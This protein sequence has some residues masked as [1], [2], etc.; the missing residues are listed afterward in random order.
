MSP[1]CSSTT[2]LQLK[3]VIQTEMGQ[4]Q[5]EKLSVIVFANKYLCLTFGI[6]VIIYVAYVSLFDN[7]SC[8]SFNLSGMLLRRC[9]LPNIGQVHLNKTSVH[10]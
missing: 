6:I 10:I 7:F 1:G 8:E 9:N 5:V 4:F 2:W 3:Y